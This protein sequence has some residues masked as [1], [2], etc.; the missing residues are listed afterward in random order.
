M[1]PPRSSATAARRSVHAGLYAAV[2]GGLCAAQSAAAQGQSVIAPPPPAFSGKAPTL[3]LYGAPEEETTPVESSLGAAQGA[4]EWGIARL[5]PS[6]FYRLMYGDGLNY[7]PGNSAKTWINEIA[8]GMLVNIGEHWTLGY[9]PTLRYYSS[10]QYKDTLDHSVFL[11]GSVAYKDWVFGLTQSYANTSEPLIET[12]AQ[13]DQQIFNTGLMA[14]YAINSTTSLELGLNQ[15]LRYSTQSVQ[16]Q[17]YNDVQSWSTMDWLSYQ[18]VP[19]L[20]LGIG[21]GAG[22]DDV[23]EGANMTYELLQGRVTWRVEKK[24]FLSI[25]GGVDIRQ[26]LDTDIGTKF[27]PIMGASLSY[28]A[29]ENTLFTLNA[30]RTVAPSYYA[31]ELTESSNVSAGLRQRLFGHL[32]GTVSGGYHV[33][34]YAAI[35]QGFGTTR[36]DTGPSF[37]ARLS[38]PFLKR[39]SAAIFYSYSENNSDNGGYS[40]DTSQVGLELGYRF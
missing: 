4:L 22:Y 38:M 15:N 27:S 30:S 31:D 14:G 18:V 19:R 25:N 29:F 26:F 11:N 17:Q 21:A 35:Q 37:M 9:T 6:V 39:A 10:K 7:S 28:Q 23:S 13:T 40:Y 34:S 20:G 5:H 8:P 2:L 24:L 12:G 3:S 32:L 1:K 36:K 33:T 16:G